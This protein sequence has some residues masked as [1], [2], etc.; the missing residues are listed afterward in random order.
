MTSPL[1]IFLS[2]YPAQVNDTLMIKVIIYPPQGVD[3]AKIYT[4][5]SYPNRLF[6]DYIDEPISFNGRIHKNRKLTF[7][8]RVIPR[9]RHSFVLNF[10]LVNLD[11]NS[12]DYTG[13]IYGSCVVDVKGQGDSSLQ[14]LMAKYAQIQEYINQYNKDELSFLELRRNII[15]VT[16]DFKN[17]F[18]LD[19]P[20]TARDSLA[21]RIK[22]L[23]DP[24]HAEAR[25]QD[26]IRIEQG[27]PIYP[28]YWTIPKKEDNQK[29]NQRRD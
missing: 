22:Q 1:K 6:F 23:L 11:S 13:F 4:A 21:L 8:T 17:D 24:I 9:Y 2:D 25:R 14:H 18:N 28:P 5:Q 26:K 20:I 29:F 27:G 10:I 19:S 15:G 12:R 7:Y 16:P 3:T